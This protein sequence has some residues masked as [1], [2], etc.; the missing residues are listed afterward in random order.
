MLKGIDISYCE[1]KV[2]WN[3]LKDSVDF[4]IIRAGYGRLLSQKD[5]MFE[6]HYADAKKAGIPVGSF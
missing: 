2:D 1:P 5:T 6:S 3:T 4:V